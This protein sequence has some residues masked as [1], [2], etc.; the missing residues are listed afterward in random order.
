[1]KRTTNILSLLLA[2]LILAA[3]LSLVSCK[4]D[5]TTAIRVEVLYCTTYFDSFLRF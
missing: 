3:G 2:A 5:E 4:K 1:M